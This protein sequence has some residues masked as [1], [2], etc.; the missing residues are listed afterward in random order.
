M[1]KVIIN[2]AIYVIGTTLFIS[3]LGHYFEQRDMGFMTEWNEIILFFIGYSILL[4]WGNYKK[5]KKEQE[6]NIN[7]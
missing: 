2:T 5:Y 6:K 7:K 3:A 1:K 4:G